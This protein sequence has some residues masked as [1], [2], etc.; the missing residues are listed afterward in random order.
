MQNSAYA[1][2]CRISLTYI[3]SAIALSGALINSH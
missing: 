3:P 1:I 2:S